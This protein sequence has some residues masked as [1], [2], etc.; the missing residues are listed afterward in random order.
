MIPTINQLYTDILNAYASKFGVN[1]NE[2]G[3]TVQAEAQVQAASLYLLYLYLGEGVKEVWPDT[4]SEEMLLRF[5]ILKPGRLPFQPTAGRY[6]VQYTGGVVNQI[7]PAGTVFKQN[8]GSGQYVLDINWVADAE[9][10]T[11]EVRALEAGFDSELIIGDLITSTNPLAAINDEV[12]VS[13]IVQAPLAGENIDDYRLLVL[14]EYKREPQGGSIGDYRSWARDAQGVRRVYPYLPTPY[15]GIIDIYV[16]ATV[17]DSLNGEPAGTPPPEMLTAVYDVLI[18]DPDITQTDE[19]RM[20]KPLDVS[21]LN[22]IAVQTVPIDVE[23]TNISDDSSATKEQIVND[24]IA[25][26]FNKR[27]YQGGVDGRTPNDIIR[28]N[29]IERIVL[30][31][32]SNYSSVVLKVDNVELSQYKVGDSISPAKYGEIPYLNAVTYLAL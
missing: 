17:E 30:N 6:M 24:I 10:G 13:S 9:T 8:N 15:A 28:L 27:P 25:Y 3:I 7:I 4:C 19:Q 26:L 1:V 2:I 23:I 21:D 31:Y 16:E 32:V 20:R 29:D 18:Q 11:F 5:G 12:T 22:V 14:E